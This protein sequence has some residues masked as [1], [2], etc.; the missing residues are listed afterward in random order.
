MVF[1][2]TWDTWYTGPLFSTTFIH[3]PI[4]TWNTGLKLL[5]TSNFITL[6]L[7]TWFTA[8]NTVLRCFSSLFSKIDRLWLRYQTTQTNTDFDRRDLLR[9]SQ[10]DVRQV[11]PNHR[12][13]SPLVRS[14]LHCSFWQYGASTGTDASDGLCSRC[15]TAQRFLNFAQLHKQ[16]HCQWY[17]CRVVGHVRLRHGHCQRLYRWNSGQ[18]LRLTLLRS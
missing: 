15:H 10:K 11:S 17:H 2:H 7:A 14:L 18:H 5:K 13:P 3:H 1:V 8:R 9:F 12:P 6:A 16:R 4:D